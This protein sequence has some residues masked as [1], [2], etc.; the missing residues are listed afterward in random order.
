MTA[1]TI[2][3]MER[4]TRTFPLQNV[5]VRDEPGG[6]LRITGTAAVFGKPSEDLGG[7]RE[8]IQRGAFK[9]ALS[10]SPDVVLLQNHDPNL[11]LARTSS[12]TLTLWED[13][14]GLNVDAVAGDTSYA[15]DLKVV[16]QRGDVS[17]MSFAFT[18]A[19]DGETW[20]MTD[21]GRQVTVRE[22]GQLFDVSVVTQPAYP[23]TSATMR[24]RDAEAQRA[25]R[26]RQDALVRQA[27]A[28]LT[29]ARDARASQ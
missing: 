1:A 17:Q 22:V 15:R 16:M 12:R 5:E 6:G 25:R 14:R 26:E 13:P 4:R 20:E 18:I 3:R 23:Q 9:R 2:E 29:I 19:P 28:S 21:S 24:S 8:R 27:E 10:E 11:V 7:F